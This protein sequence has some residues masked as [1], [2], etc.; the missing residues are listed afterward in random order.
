M[1]LLF[2]SVITNLIV[3]LYV[4]IVYFIWGVYINKYFNFSIES[5][6][7]F[8]YNLSETSSKSLVH[9]LFTRDSTYRLYKFIQIFM[10]DDFLYRTIR[11]ISVQ[12]VEK[13]TDSFNMDVLDIAITRLLQ[14][15]YPMSMLLAKDTCINIINVVIYRRYNWL[16]SMIS[17]VG[18]F[19]KKIISRSA[20]FHCCINYFYFSI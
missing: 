8:F 13:H 10:P 2:P 5:N 7:R 4:S 6:V 15:E 1:K 17:F 19:I 14:N 3:H 18:Q 20:R 16:I 11:N 9:V 12:N